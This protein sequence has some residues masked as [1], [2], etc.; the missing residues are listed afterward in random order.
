LGAQVVIGK[1][2]LAGTEETLSDVTVRLLFPDG[3]QASYT[4]SDSAGEFGMTVPRLGP[5]SLLAERIGLATVTT[6]EFRVGLSEEVE[7]VLRM[8]V[9]A[10]PLEPLVVVARSAIE[11]GLL[12]GYYERMERQQRL[13]F[14]HFL[15]RDQIDDR[16]ALDVADLLRDIPRVRVV[17]RGSGSNRLPSVVFLGTGGECSPAVFIDGVP[18]NRGGAAG[19][20][21]VVDEILRPYDLEG[22]EVY[23]GITE[24]PGEY[25]DDQHC[26]LILLWTRRDLEA[27]HSLSLNRVM[28]AFGIFLTF[29]F[30]LAK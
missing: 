4:V 14:S 18:Q 1:T 22:I 12:T 17:Q 8:S 24:M 3:R 25:Y 27:G 15:T 29:V 16:Q 20:A 2:V 28:A 5:Y 10:V 6:P 30:L 23:R 7:V 26:G 21:A 11:L 9:E 13:G 19:T